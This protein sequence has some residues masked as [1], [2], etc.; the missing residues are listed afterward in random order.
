V[1]D[2]E[3]DVITKINES[4][5]L[6]RSLQ[7][8]LRE[9][10][11]LLSVPDPSIEE[12]EKKQA[13]LEAFPRLESLA[14]LGPLVL[15]ER[16]G[17]RTRIDEIKTQRSN[18]RARREDFVRLARDAGWDVQSTGTAD[19][20]GPFKIH[21]D[22]RTSNVYFA[23]YRVKRISHPSG[24][25]VFDALTKMSKKMEVDALKGWNEFMDRAIAMQD[26]IS[27]TEPVPWGELLT[28]IACDKAQQKRLGRIFNYRLALLVSGRAPGG[29]KA[30]VVPPALAEQRFAWK[31]PRLDRPND[32]IRVHRVRLKK[33]T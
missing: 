6:L 28:A 5:R 7:K 31:V 8:I 13:K 24:G 25:N 14:G 18:V 27:A 3:I 12:I 33:N 16:E 32:V 19:F 15:N 20:V 9:L 2:P 30:V 10:G 21:H 26:R 22:E 29:W 17:Y 1:T 23:K 11:K 4:I